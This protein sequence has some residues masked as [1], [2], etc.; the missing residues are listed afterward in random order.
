MKRLLLL[1]LFLFSGISINAQS[2]SI[3]YKALIKDNLGNVVAN[4]NIFIQF[5]ILSGPTLTNVFQE[6]HNAFTDS[7]GIV[8]LSIGNGTVDSGN[9]ANID[10]GSEDHFLNVQIDTGSGLIDMGTTAFNA[11]PYALSANSV[12]KE[13]IAVDDLSDAKQDTNGSSLFI[14]IGSGDN[15]VETINASN[16]GIGNSSLLQNTTGN[17][18]TALGYF[19]LS[20]NTTGSGNTAIGR[21]SLESNIDGMSNVSIGGGTLLN[22]ISGSNNVAVGQVALALNTTGINNTA[23]GYRAGYNNSEGIGNLFLGYEAGYNELGSHKLYIETSSLSSDNP[24]IYGEFNNNILRVNGTFQIGNP[25]DTGFAFP[26]TDGA[27][28]QILQTNG[29]GVLT[30]QNQ[31]LSGANSLDELSDVRVSGNSYYFGSQS[32]QNDTS[33]IGQNIGIGLDA[34]TSNTSGRFNVGIGH[35]ALAL[36]ETGL[37]NVGVGDGVLGSIIN[38]NQNSALGVQALRLNNGNRNTAVGAFSLN[39]NT[40][41][42]LNT[43]VGSNS[44]FSN[45]IGSGNVFIGNYAGFNETGS[46]KLY[47]ESSITQTDN[48]LIY[49]EFDTNILRANGTLQIGNPTDTGFAFPSIDGTANQILQ[50]D[51]NG[52][53]TWQDQNPSGA[54]SLDELSDVRVIGSSY[55][56]G[57]QSGQ[58]DTSTIGQNTGIGQNSLASNTS[59]RFNVGIG[60]FALVLN[61][62]GSNNTGLGSSVMNNMINGSFNSALGRQALRLNNGSGNTAIGALSLDGNTTG[63]LN[64]AVG[65]YAG[66]FNDGSENVFIG[67]YAGSNETGSNKLY[68]ESSIAETDNPLIYGEFDTNILRANGTLQIG[69]PA[70]TGFAFPSTDGTANQI[71]QTDGNGTLTWQ[72]QIVGG[73]TSFNELSDAQS[74][75]SSYF[76]GN[77]SGTND[78]GTN[79]NIG[80]GN[81]SLSNNTTGQYNNAIGQ[82]ALFNNTTGIRNV[83]V[84]AFSMSAN[85]SGEENIAI[86]YTSLNSNTIGS[87]NQAIGDAA[88]FNNTEGNANT[89]IGNE[90]MFSNS[91]GFNNVAVG[92]ISLR[93]NTTGFSNSAFGL[94][95]LSQNTTGN[96]NTAL[97][98]S[99]MNGNTTG[100]SNIAIGSNSGTGITTG[101][102]NTVIGTGAQVPNGAGNNQVRIGNTNVTYAGVQVGWTI[103]SDRRWKEEIRELPYGLN[104]VNNLEPVDYVRKNNELKTKETGFIAQ[105]VEK[106]LKELGYE[107]SGLI[108]KD[109]NGLMSI[110][111]NDFI[112]ILTKAIQEQ[113][114]IIEGQKY[115]I[116][117]LT[118]ELSITKDQQ[119]NMEKRLTKIEALLNT[120]EK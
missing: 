64:T 36:N 95:A 52:V 8:I 81:F 1:S 30:W 23:L 69:N 20:S 75:G 99:A 96:D 84:G 80:I 60:H 14:G 48:P 34:L 110:R 6:T 7:N 66:V 85:I 111:Y 62:T 72:D 79:V 70:N 24:L 82:Q 2:N 17:Q 59:G 108:H 21:G 4:Q 39:N 28:N 13:T 11:V 43:A 89:A 27:A 114:L 18:N 56:F 71:L 113:Q 119:S 51:G 88:L 103:T 10:W 67:N 46:N 68:I 104:M 42:I 22:N 29:N 55:Y 54:N 106:L 101:S 116:N 107:D 61:E 93:N 65:Y 109:E 77:N 94:N 16:T 41:G 45:L 86:G 83:A 31:N 50:T 91:T 78:D 26:S 98:V 40:S 100:G 3:N 15:N 92:N 35:A 47:I 97:G 105:D 87:V 32:G 117:S 120:T 25:E 19:S 90:T 12:Q 102:N 63:S 9:F 38:G 76:L 112:A 44:G 49:G 53:L 33:T 58:N 37:E 73:A 5:Q 57:T 115:E 118:S 74:D